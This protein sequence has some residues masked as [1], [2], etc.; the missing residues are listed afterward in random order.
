[1]K[2]KSEVLVLIPTFN[3]C[4]TI[5]KTLLEVRAHNPDVD[6]LVLDDSSPD[7]TAEIVL[8]IAE[9]DSRVHLLVRAKKEG[10]GK[11]YL[12]GFEWGLGRA[13]HHFVEMD[14]DGSHRAIDLAKLLRHRDEADRVIGSR[15]T[16]GGSVRHWPWHRRFI[17]RVGNRYAAWALGSK[18]R[19]LTAGFRVYSR[20]LLE[21]LPLGTV[22]AQGYGFQVELAWRAEQLGAKILEIPI[23]FVEREQGT[24]KMTT[25]IVLEAL[26]LVTKWGIAQRRSGRR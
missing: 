23:E 2:P 14:A 24:S 10:L 5:E 18:V 22:S 11:A 25:G 21:T 19:D 4:E 13:Y 17:S 8:A 9:N 7:G 16:E 26:R 15:W 1:M 3:E 6:I 12:A 20:D